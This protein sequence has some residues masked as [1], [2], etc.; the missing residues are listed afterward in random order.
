MSTNSQDQEIDLG[1]L[2]SKASGFFKS[3]I[4]NFFDLI[5]F[6]QKKIVIIIVLLIIGVAFAYLVDGK[7]K[8]EHELSLIPNF[9]SN[10]Y[11]YKKI[12]EL[13]TKL[14]EKDPVFFKNLGIKNY[15]D[16]ISIKIEAF[17]A[18]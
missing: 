15:E 13:D 9:G 10:E 4:N 12:D 18:V 16:I 3:I 14:R 11:L 8:Y 6:I 1:K 17:S 5:F 2:F 7:K